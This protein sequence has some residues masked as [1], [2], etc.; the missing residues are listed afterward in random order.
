MFKKIHQCIELLTC[1]NDLL[2]I[3][4]LLYIYDNQHY[5]TL[6]S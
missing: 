5:H 3:E 1:T 4:D 2:I 6:V